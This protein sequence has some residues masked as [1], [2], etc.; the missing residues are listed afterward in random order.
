MINLFSYE[1]ITELRLCVKKDNMKAINLYLASG[2]F[3]DKNLT[4]YRLNPTEV[5]TAGA[6][7]R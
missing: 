3:I 6:E 2:F 7:A 5:T 4:Y 1:T